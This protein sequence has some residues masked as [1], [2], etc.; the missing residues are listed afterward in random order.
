MAFAKLKAH[1]R[2]LEARSFECVLEA[3][4]SICD[5]FTPTECQNYFRAAGYSS[6]PGFAETSLKAY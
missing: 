3:L 5:L 4:G 6:A 2:R 1:L